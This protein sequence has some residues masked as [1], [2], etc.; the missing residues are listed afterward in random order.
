MKGVLRLIVQ[1]VIYCPCHP[2]VI[3]LEK[4]GIDNWNVYFPPQKNQ[5]NMAILC[6]LIPKLIHS[7]LHA[8]IH[9]YSIANRISE[10][11]TGF[12]QSRKS[13]IYLLGIC[14]TLH[15]K[16]KSCFGISMGVYTSLKKLPLFLVL[17]WHCVIPAKYPFE[18]RRHQQGA[19]RC[20]RGGLG[21]IVTASLPYIFLRLCNYCA[22]SEKDTSYLKR[23]GEVQHV[24]KY[25]FS[26]RS[27]ALHL[28]IL[29]HIF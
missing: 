20:F 22:N 12:A 11:N 10:I 8:Q 18:L 29:H 26:F 24:P 17:H 16:P 1:P 9:L 7:R 6:L 14:H 25:L 3:K 15:L 27:K 21:C 13:K 5:C 4:V 19:R 28:P 2:E 23:C